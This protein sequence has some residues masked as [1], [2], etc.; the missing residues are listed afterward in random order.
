MAW[1][2]AGLVVIWIVGARVIKKEKARIHAESARFKAYMIH[3]NY[4]ALCRKSVRLVLALP[5]ETRK[6]A[7]VNLPPCLSALEALPPE[8]EALEASYI[9]P[10]VPT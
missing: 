4:L 1:G 3:E 2:L 10:F 9:R 8:R 5:F 6:S 7:L